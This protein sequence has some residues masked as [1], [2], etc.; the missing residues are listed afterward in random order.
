MR[1][2]GAVGEHLT[3]IIKVMDLNR[4]LKTTMH[5]KVMI[6]LGRIANKHL[7]YSWFPHLLS[8]EFRDYWMRK[9]RIRILKM[10][11][12]IFMKLDFYTNCFDYIG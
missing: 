12:E 4:P 11:S 9:I 8:N 2:L 1:N 5:S 7:Y 6:A 3:L 10:I